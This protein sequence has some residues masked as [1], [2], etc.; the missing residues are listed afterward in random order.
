MARWRKVVLVSGVID[1]VGD[2]ALELP[3]AL[4]KVEGVEPGEDLAVVDV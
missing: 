1:G 3:V 4:T 2:N